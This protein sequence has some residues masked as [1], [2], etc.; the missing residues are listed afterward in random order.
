MLP[1]AGLNNSFWGEAIATATYLRNRMVSA[2]IKSP[3][4]LRYGKNP[5]LKNIHVFSCIVYIHIPDGDRKKLDKKAQK[6]RFI[7]YTETAGNY[8]VWDGNKQKYYVRHDVVFNEND[9]SKSQDI[10]EQEPEGY[11]IAFT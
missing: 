5:N 6:L 1:H 11:L 4:Q 7:G 8:T 10:P 2:A 9:F 3:Y